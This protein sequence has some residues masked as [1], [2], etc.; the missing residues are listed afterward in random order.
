MGKEKS[1][2]PR[3]GPLV[4]NTQKRPRISSD[5]EN[6]HKKYPSWRISKM[7][8]V[9]PFGWHDL[10]E[11]TLAYIRR[12]LGEFENRTWGEILNSHH[13]HNVEIAILCKE[14]RNRLEAIRQSDIDELLSLRL[15]GPERVWGILSEGV[16]TLLWWDPNHQVCPSLKK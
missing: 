2:K 5:P 4:P 13:N 14:A 10:D 7:E 1:K 3:L 15:S 11:P 16:C 8:M 6:F 9:D 12:K